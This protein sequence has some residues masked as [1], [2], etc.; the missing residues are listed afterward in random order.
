MYITNVIVLLGKLFV[1]KILRYSTIYFDLFLLTW[2]KEWIFVTAGADYL[3]DNRVV[4]PPL[5]RS[6]LWKLPAPLG[7]LPPWK[8]MKG[9]NYSR[10]AQNDTFLVF[11]EGTSTWIYPLARFTSDFWENSELNCAIV[12]RFTPPKLKFPL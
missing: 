10:Y 2:T 4:T 5:T 9:K 12:L 6:E 7:I 8:W 1:S 3:G 11:F